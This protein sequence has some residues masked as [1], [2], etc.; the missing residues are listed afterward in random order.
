MFAGTI[1]EEEE[2]E[3]EVDE[4]EDDEDEGERDAAVVAEESPKEM[5]VEMPSARGCDGNEE[6]EGVDE[7]NNPPKRECISCIPSHSVVIEVGWE[8]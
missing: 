2:E 6:E 5:R 1:A 8:E 4:D 3:E 7:L